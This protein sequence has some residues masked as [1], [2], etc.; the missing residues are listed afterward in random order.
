MVATD[1]VSAPLKLSLG[2]NISHLPNTLPLLTSLITFPFSSRPIYIEYVQYIQQVIQYM[3]TII[4]KIF[5][6]RNESCLGIL[7]HIHIILSHQHTSIW[8][9]QLPNISQMQVQMTFLFQGECTNISICIPTFIQKAQLLES[10]Q[11]QQA[12][13][14]RNQRLQDLIRNST[15][16]WFLLKQKA[17][18][19]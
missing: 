11:S 6:S 12:L 15:Y 10:Q 13:S 17:A 18:T 19:G 14:F 9:E 2:R 4:H 16:C 1:I 5:C 3:G 7:K 8:L